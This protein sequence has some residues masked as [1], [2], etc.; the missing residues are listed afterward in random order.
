MPQPYLPV[1]KQKPFNLHLFVFACS[2]PS[3]YR[4]SQ[5]ENFIL[6]A[7]SLFLGHE[8]SRSRCPSRPP[9]RDPRNDTTT[10]SHPTISSPTLQDRLSE[11]RRALSSSLA[12]MSSA[13]E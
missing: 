4:P 2:I 5:L 11:K 10:S 7:L 3:T 9:K 8:S 12:H 1:S 6:Q 13:S